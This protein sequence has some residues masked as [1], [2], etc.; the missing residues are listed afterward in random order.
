M[1]FGK[2]LALQTAFLGGLLQAYIKLVSEIP[3][4]PT[5]YTFVNT[6]SFKGCRQWDNLFSSRVL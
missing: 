4:C 2:G 5:A 1:T 6:I 3:L